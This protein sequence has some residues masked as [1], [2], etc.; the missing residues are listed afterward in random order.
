MKSVSTLTIAIS[1]L[2]LF[3]VESLAQQQWEGSTDINGKIHRRGDVGIGTTTPIDKLEVEGGQLTVDGAGR[4][5]AIRFRKNDTMMWTILTA[6]WIGGSVPGR[7]GGDDLRLR[8]ETTGR[9]VI[10]FERHSNNVGIG[11]TNP[12]SKLHVK[13]GT[14]A[15]IT[16]ESNATKTALLS[17]YDG[18]IAAFVIAKDAH[19]LSDE[20]YMTINKDGR[21]GIGTTWLDHRL[22][23]WGNA[24]KSQGGGSWATWSDIRLKNKQEEF[25]AGL[26]EIMM[27]RP[28][29]YRYRKDNPLGLIDQGDHI[30]LSA[31]EVQKVIP[32][33]VSKNNKGY[34]MLNNDPIIWAMLNAIKEQ[35]RKIEELETKLNERL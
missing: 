2:M 34:L 23:V 19:S 15:S 29:R 26:K 28:I 10:T 11:T 32:E 25:D 18:D 17:G 13:G 4:L 33:A 20:W 6:P 30:G 9:D 22:N 24:I 16:L 1:T 35:Q 27:L 5:A 7:V 8:N 31:Q 12:D 3:N 14:S 21:V